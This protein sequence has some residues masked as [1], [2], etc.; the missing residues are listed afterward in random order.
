MNKLK[1]LPKLE[2]Q[3]WFNEFTFDGKTLVKITDTYWRQF[4]FFEPI[5]IGKQFRFEVKIVKS[6]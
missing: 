6:R 5:T 2:S 3:K 4:V 1:T